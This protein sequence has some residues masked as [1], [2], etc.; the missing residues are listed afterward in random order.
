[1]QVGGSISGSVDSNYIYT[2][3]YDNVTI[4]YTINTNA[5]SVYAN[6]V[7][8]I[9]N[10]P[11]Y[12]SSPVGMSGVFIANAIRQGAVSDNSQIY[13]NIK[14]SVWAGGAINGSSLK[15]KD[16]KDF[17]NSGYGVQGGVKLFDN[18]KIVGGV[19]VS[20]NESSLEQDLEKADFNELGF[21]VYGGF[22]GEK[23]DLKAVIGYG[24]QNTAAKNDIAKADFDSTAIKFGLEGE[25][26]LSEFWK[27]F[28]EI[29][30]G[31]V[32]NDKINEKIDGQTVS[33]ID[34]DSYFRLSLSAGLKIERNEE[35]LS[36][37]AK[38]Y[39]GFLAAGANPEFS[40]KPINGR[41]K[42]IDATDESSIYVGLGIGV[43]IPIND[44]VSVFLNGDTNINTDMLNYRGNAGLSYRF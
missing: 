39:L 16:Y 22:F 1:M 5:N 7:D 24:I 10:N 34:A 37:Y 26:K 21:G 28:A 8:V 12:Y 30:G 23:V 3:A 14:E 31:Y 35:W 20:Y 44:K 2:S 40:Q 4:K 25:Y 29:A 41:S 19:F 9:I 15:D 32:S 6:I 17:K 13:S 36:W 27:P 38:G 42:T 43:S 33:V 18:D 11:S